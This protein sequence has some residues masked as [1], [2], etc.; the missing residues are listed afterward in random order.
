MRK[1]TIIKSI[2]EIENTKGYQAFEPISMPLERFMERSKIL[3]DAQYGLSHSGTT[4]LD[5]VMVEYKEKI[6][7]NKK[8]EAVF[9]AMKRTFE[10][11][12]GSLL[13]EIAH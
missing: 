1:T 5:T 9:L 8:V 13:I 11:I 3:S 4:P 7:S 2:P 6:K 12:N 10:R